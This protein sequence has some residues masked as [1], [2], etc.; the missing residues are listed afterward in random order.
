LRGVQGRIEDNVF[1]RTSGPGI[2]IA[3]EPNW[4]EGPVPRDVVI[5]GNRLLSVGLDANGQGYA[6]IMVMGLGLQG[7]SPCPGV[8]NIRIEDSTIADP[9]AQGIFVS[10][11]DGVRLAGNRI[12]ADGSRRFA[13]S[14]ALGISASD[15]VVVAGLVIR[16]SRPNTL[17]GIQIA[18][19]VAA[20]TSGITIDGLA[21]QLPPKT[22]PV[23]D[24]RPAVRK[25][26]KTR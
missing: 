24:R 12:T 25:A 26:S 21:A 11:C 1:Q 13:S 9:P 8:K 22:V 20:G 10:G 4:P 19:S 15:H 23:L 16:D 5:R 3:N 6:A 2:V 7:L 18:A 17:C 14:T